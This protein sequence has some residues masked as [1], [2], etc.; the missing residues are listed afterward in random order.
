MSGV[1]TLYREYSYVGG[2]WTGGVDLDQNPGEEHNPEIYNVPPQNATDAL[3]REHDWQ[4][5]LAQQARDA[6]QEDV[7]RQITINADMALAPSVA[8]CQHFN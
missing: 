4:Y 6:G 8:S 3:A 1:Y 2:R 7:A 5:G